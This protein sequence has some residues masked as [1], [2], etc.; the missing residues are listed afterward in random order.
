[1]NPVAVGDLFANRLPGRAIDKNLICAMHW[2][3]LEHQAHNYS[4]V[5]YEVFAPRHFGPL[6]PFHLVA[7]S[8][9]VPVTST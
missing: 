2:H 4:L 6:G 8:Q 1:M 7:R 5:W 3:L 9:L